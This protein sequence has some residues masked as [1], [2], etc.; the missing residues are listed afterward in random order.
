MGSACPL[1][2][3]IIALRT[4][5]MSAESLRVQGHEQIVTT[6]KN[7]G[8]AAR[9]L[10]PG[11]GSVLKVLSTGARQ[12]PLLTLTTG[13]PYRFSFAAEKCRPLGLSI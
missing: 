6:R 8:V 3:F 9:P 4:W 13:L 1:T 12:M 2:N 5:G 11:G 10:P 7:G